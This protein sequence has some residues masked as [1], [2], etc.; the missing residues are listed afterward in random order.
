MKI[1]KLLSKFSAYMSLSTEIEKKRTE[2]VMKSFRKEK[3]LV[4]NAEFGRMARSSYKGSP[5]LS[6]EE[7]IG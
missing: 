4:L 1:I 5:L 7:T 6:T 2:S 3:S